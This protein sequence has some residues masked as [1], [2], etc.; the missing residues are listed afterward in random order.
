MAYFVS[1]I[2]ILTPSAAAASYTVDLSGYT[3]LADDYVCVFFLASTS[4]GPTIS[5]TSGG[6]STWSFVKSDGTGQT[7]PCGMAYAKVAAGP[8]ISNPTLSLSSGTAPWQVFV[9]I[10]RDADATTFKDANSAATS[11]NNVVSLAT[12]AFTPANNNCLVVYVGANRAAAVD[13]HNRYSEDLVCAAKQSFNEGAEKSGLSVSY[14]QQGTA[15]AAQKTLYVGDGVKLATAVIAINNKSGGKLQKFASTVGLTRVAWLGSFGAANLDNHTTGA[16][17]NGG[18]TWDGTGKINSITVSSTAGTK[19]TGGSF[20]SF[21]GTAWGIGDVITCSLNTAGAWQGLKYTLNSSTDM[22]GKLFSIEFSISTPTTPIGDEGSIVAFKDASGNFVAYSLSRKFGTASTTLYQAVIAVGY[23]TAYAS[24]GAINWAAITDV[25]ILM[26]RINSSGLG[27]TIAIRHMYLLAPMT[28][29]GGSSVNPMTVLDANRALCGWGQLGLSNIHGDAVRLKTSL[30]IGD[31]ST[32]TY[33]DATATLINYPPAYNAISSREFNVPTNYI[34]FR[35]KAGASDTIIDGYSS[36]S[37]REQQDYVIDASSS[38]SATYTNSSKFILGM[39]PTLLAG[40]SFSGYTFKSCGTLNTKGS[41]LT[42]CDVVATTSTNAA[43]SIDTSGSTLDGCEID[44]TD[45]SA[46]YHI[47]LGTA[48]T[49]VT[50]TDVTFTGTPAVDTVHVLATTGTVTISISGTTSLVAGDVTSAGAT[51]VISA[52]ALYQS[53]TVSNITTTSRV[54]IYDTTNSVELYNDVPGATSKTWTNTTAA[55]TYG[56]FTPRVRISD[57]VTTTAKQFI[58]ATLSDCGTTSSDKDQSYRAS[59]VAD[60]T[61]NTNA[62]DGP[63]IYATSGITFTDAAT[64]LVNCNIAGGGVTWPTIYACFVHWMNTATGIADDIAYIDAPDT[65]NY[66][67]TSMKIRNTSATD[68]TVTGGWGRDA[69]TGLSKDI[70]DTAGSTGNIFLAPDHVIPF[71][72][73]SSV[74]ASDK[75]DIA[76]AVLSAASSTPIHSDFRKAIGQDYHGDGSEGDKLRSTL[77]P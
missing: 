39:A 43:V 46:N 53:V 28:M 23:G 77:I 29:V 11:G 52:P 42:S 31:G 58:E 40:E 67:L 48:V 27:R 75:T 45:T 10:V 59:Q 37:A 55:S 13:A 20:P 70:I 49:A 73:G 61:Y 35:I 38:T 33:Y 74:T 76:A 3:V 63:S 64:D 54:Q 14:I 72:T 1:D 7:P 36:I 17:D 4:A 56:T 21:D 47:E 16:P 22:S 8:T 6:G 62:I 57:V 18:V 60:T 15:S 30:Q 44:L 68:L 34:E 41:N 19:T 26:H 9:G 25:S 32:E 2:E 71:A 66:L 12:A 5:E 51:V 69:T 50:L 24:N 65:A